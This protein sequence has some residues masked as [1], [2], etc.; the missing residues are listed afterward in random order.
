[1][2]RLFLLKF[3]QIFKRNKSTNLLLLCHLLQQLQM[4]QL[5]PQNVLPSA[6]ILADQAKIT[7]I[8]HPNTIDKPQH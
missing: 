5:W 3:K 8:L 2:K 4:V 6:Q 7:D 1:M